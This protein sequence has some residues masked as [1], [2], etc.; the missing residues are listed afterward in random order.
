MNSL[1][2]LFATMIAAFALVVPVGYGQTETYGPPSLQAKWLKEGLIITAQHLAWERVQGVG[3]IYEHKEDLTD[4]I[5]LT[6]VNDQMGK[7]SAD[8]EVKIDLGPAKNTVPDDFDTVVVSLKLKSGE[9]LSRPVEVRLVNADAVRAP[10]SEGEAIDSSNPLV[11]FTYRRKEALIRQATATA[12]PR[13][14]FRMEGEK[15]V[16]IVKG[17]TSDDVQNIIFSSI[18]GYDKSDYLHTD[19]SRQMAWIVNTKDGFTLILE[20]DG[21]ELV[22]TEAQEVVLVLDN[23]TGLTAPILHPSPPTQ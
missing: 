15:A 23:N 18:A 10:L 6:L 3:L 14:E 11:Q 4:L 13:L 20:T 5:K 8:H 17:A 19:F 16:L 7:N 9:V 1:P 22:D 21:I 12:S 2:M